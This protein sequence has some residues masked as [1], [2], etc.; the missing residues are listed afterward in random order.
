[1]SHALLDEDP[2]CSREELADDLPAFVD[3]LHATL[4]GEVA[5]KDAAPL[6]GPRATGARQGLQRQR[7]GFEPATIAR[8]FGKICEIIMS[9]A[10]QE[11][12]HFDAA[13]FKVFNRAIDAGI[14]SGLEEYWSAS[15]AETER[16]L[17]VRIGFLAHE[18]RNALSTA[19][20]AFDAIQSGQ[21]GPGSRTASVLGRS[22]GQ[23]Q[24]LI[25]HTMAE[26]RLRSSAKPRI[27]RLS[28]VNQLCDV[29][30]PL[31]PD[32]G[33]QIELDVDDSLEVHADAQLLGSAVMNLVQNALKF[34][35]DGGTVHVRAGH[36][37]ADEVFIEI[38][39]ECGGLPAGAAGELFDPFVQRGADRS[40]AGLGL[41]IT[42]DVMALQG[43]SVD[44]QDLPGRGCIFTL[45]LRPS[46]S[47]GRA[48]LGT[49][50]G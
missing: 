8:Y 13:E 1:M 49:A 19:T 38:E 28:L 30:A 15:R 36:G 31:R 17:E 50:G 26:V 23:M 21:V 45:H 37:P 35:R 40:G 20:M 43:G 12:R 25:A 18:L 41:A 7:L 33:V 42:R 4:R 14:A 9:L 2:A 39:D 32:R 3:G 46:A 5:R 48:R 24:D 34:T 29:I 22:L 44:V 16:N 10:E 47:N 27:E 11:G 6:A